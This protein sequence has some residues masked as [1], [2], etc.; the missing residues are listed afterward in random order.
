[1]RDMAAIDA[2]IGANQDRPLSSLDRT[3]KVAKWRNPRARGGRR[4]DGNR[5]Y[6]AARSAAAAAGFRVPTEDAV[7]Q[8][9]PQSRGGG[10]VFENRISGF[11]KVKPGCYTK[12]VF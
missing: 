1:M 6:R 12:T 2:L 11:L 7:I 8:G 5:R 3:L 10:P 4:Q 9:G